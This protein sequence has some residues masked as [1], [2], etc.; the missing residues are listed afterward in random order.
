[1]DLLIGE[2]P[3]WKKI[4]QYE[5]DTWI[6]NDKNFNL[7]PSIQIQLIL[8]VMSKKKSKKEANKKDKKKKDKKS[9]L[10]KLKVGKKKDKKKKDKKKKDAKKKDS[11]KKKSAK[12]KKDNPAPLQAAALEPKPIVKTVRKPRPATKRIPAPKPKPKPTPKS[13]AATGAVNHSS[14]Y[15]VF[16]AIAKIRAIKNRDELLA[17]IKGEKRVTITKVIPAALNKLKH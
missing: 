3:A 16:E 13:K 4:R 12:K 15:K 11:K 17:F 10:A 2:N 5:I 6:V 14:N 9:I 1:M 8:L 7:G